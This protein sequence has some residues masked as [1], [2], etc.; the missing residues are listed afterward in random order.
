MPMIFVERNNGQIDYTHRLVRDGM[1][2]GIDEENIKDMNSTILEYLKS[3]PAD[4]ELRMD[5]MV[6]YC[7][8]LDNKKYFV[9]Y[10][11][12]H[13][14]NKDGVALEKVAQELY[15]I[16]MSDNGEWYESV[17]K[18]VEG[19]SYGMNMGDF[20][21][22]FFDDSFVRGS[23]LEHE[24][25]LKIW[26][27]VSQIFLQ[28]YEENKTQK[29]Y[30]YYSISCNYVGGIYEKQGKLEEAL[31]KYEEGMKIRQKLAQE[32]GTPDSQR[33]YSA[34]CN[35]VG[36]IYEKQGK[37]EEALKKYEE[38]LKISQKLAQEQGTPDSQRDYSVSC[39]NVGR[40][41]EKQRKL[42]EALKKYKECLKID[43]KLSE[44]QKTP[45][46]YRDYIISCNDVGRIY[47]KQGKTTKAKKY[48]ELAISIIKNSPIYLKYNPNYRL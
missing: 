7:Y 46:S 19:Y 4:D 38:D 36:G 13:V 24:I 8:A 33:E 1:L 3:L 10:I 21:S 18:S 28:C 41:Y 45:D 35:K 9:E 14:K 6:Y 48:D 22:G 2:R 11:E 30:R 12:E 43:Q 34:S 44:E 26:N 37:L 27:C 15:W 40:I 25:R 32:Q 47:E 17:L 31:K 20:V 5:E 23:L 29:S 42:V 39:N 16:C